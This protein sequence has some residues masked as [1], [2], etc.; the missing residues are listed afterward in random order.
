LLTPAYLSALPD[1]LSILY[2]E[3]EDDII[4]DI[5][6]RLGKVDF[7]SI[8]SSAEWQIKKATELNL[9]RTQLIDRLASVS[10]RSVK[11]VTTLFA[12]ANIKT[13]DF[14]RQVMGDIN[15]YSESQQQLLNAGIKK[16]NGELRNLTRNTIIET[17]NEYNK[18]IDSAYLQVST[19]A[20]SQQQAVSMALKKLAKDGLLTAV[21]ESATGK[22]TVQNLDGV[23]RRAVVTGINQTTAQLQLDRLD[24]V[25]WDLVEVTSHAGSRP[26]HAQWQGKIFSRNG[27]SKQYGDFV[28]STNYGAVDG[29]CGANC[30][31][32][33]YPFLEGV[34]EKAF[35]QYV[36][37]RK[38]GE[39]PQQAND[40]VYEESQTQRY[41]ERQI[42]S[43]KRQG[44]ALASA[45]LDNS[46]EV[47]KVA[48]WQG[49]MRQHIKATG[50]TRRYTREGGSPVRFKGTKPLNQSTN[51][52]ATVK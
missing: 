16:C 33:F 5:A 34:S 12:N 20:F 22:K 51:R 2:S 38:A 26:S 6:K 49:K 4:N 30:R 45:G 42:R 14:D 1:E 50:R 37:P 47:A 29:L 39:T 24:A 21:Y 35:D 13:M 32:N 28:S 7:T 19:G 31:H 44:D 9:T 10:G 23:V 18:I 40:R 8:S 43:W 27:T 3:V 15:F 48:E 11:E 36:T 52:Q 25:G 46:K 17:S 41:I